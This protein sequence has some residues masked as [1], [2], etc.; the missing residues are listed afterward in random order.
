MYTILNLPT[1]PDIGCN[2]VWPL[3]DDFDTSLANFH[4]RAE[5]ERLVSLGP[6][7]RYKLQRRNY[8]IIDGYLNFGSSRLWW[9]QMTSW[10]VS[11]E[12][13]PGGLSTGR[14]THAH[15]PRVRTL[16]EEVPLKTNWGCFNRG[17]SCNFL[18][19]LW[20]LQRV[21]CSCV[22]ELLFGTNEV[23]VRAVS[24]SLLTILVRR[25]SYNNGWIYEIL[26]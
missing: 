16:S 25:Y 7:H 9:P 26:L 2:D 11:L 20:F 8:V 19:I 5:C 21:I 15:I 13:P 4:K 24:V 6:C 3:S 23:V 1:T 12:S 14:E 10:G 18:A 17:G 22:F